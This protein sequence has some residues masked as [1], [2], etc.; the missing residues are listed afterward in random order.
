MPDKNCAK[1]EAAVSDEALERG[2]VEISGDK[3]YCS[4]CAGKLRTGRGEEAEELRKS[5][6]TAANPVANAAPQEKPKPGKKPGNL[7]R[8]KPAKRRANRNSPRKKLRES[9]LHQSSRRSKNSKAHWYSG[10]Y[11]PHLVIAGLCLAGMVLALVALNLVST[12]KKVAAVRTRPHLTDYGEGIGRLMSEAETL[13]KQDRNKEAVAIYRRVVSMANARAE[14]A[15]KDGD[16][17]LAARSEKLAT[18]ANRRI[19]GIYKQTPLSGR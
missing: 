14:K 5:E 3:R 19:Y 6:A 8:K 10:L 18:W 11:R 13:E 2:A 7:S 1:C 9:N 17:G 4:V 12:E 16:R 15:R